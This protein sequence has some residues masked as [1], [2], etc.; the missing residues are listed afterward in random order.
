M[1][2]IA[3]LPLREGYRAVFRNVDIDRQKAK[4]MQLRVLKCEQVT[5]PAGVFETYRIAVEPAEGGAGTTTIWVEKQQRKPVKY[6]SVLP[7]MGGA[8]LTAELLGS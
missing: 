8:V 6:Q 5:V 3:A 1:E 2:S 4:W 7:E